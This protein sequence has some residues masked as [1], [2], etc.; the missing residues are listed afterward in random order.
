MRTLQRLRAPSALLRPHRRPHARDTRDSSLAHAA[1]V[2]GVLDVVFNVAVG[3]TDYELSVT[4]E[5]GL[6]GKHLL[7]LVRRPWHEWWMWWWRRL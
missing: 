7:R 6:E 2:Q 1:A 4:A 5:N 3:L